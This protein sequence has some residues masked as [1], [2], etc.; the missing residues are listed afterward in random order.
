M[1]QSRYKSMDRKRRLV[2]ELTAKEKRATSGE[3]TKYDGTRICERLHCELINHIALY[4]AADAKLFNSL[5]SL[6][7]EWEGD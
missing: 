6:E 1:P 3:D 7:V 5:P 4:L 2:V